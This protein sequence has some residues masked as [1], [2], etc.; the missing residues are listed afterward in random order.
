[1]TGKLRRRHVGPRERQAAGCGRRDRRT[2]RPAA[3]GRTTGL[4]PAGRADGSAGADARD[5][6]LG[7]T[8]KR[9]PG[10]AQRIPHPAQHS[11]LIR[12]C[13]SCE[14]PDQGAGDGS[15]WAPATPRTSPGR[16]PR[17]RA[18]TARG[19]GPDPRRSLPPTAAR[20]TVSPRP[21]AGG[22]SQPDSAPP[23]G[24]RGDLRRL[25]RARPGPVARR[26]GVDRPRRPAVRG[27][28][29]PAWPSRG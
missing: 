21:A 8:I 28:G 18:A 22:Y 7:A 25:T 29:R 16:S 11:L 13:R 10:S 12:S 14:R 1:M 23:P 3:I 27:R 2:P 9:R 15:A 24:V 20:R 26:G 17:G 6:A 5:P 4:S 19:G